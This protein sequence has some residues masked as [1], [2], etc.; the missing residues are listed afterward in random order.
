MND[1]RLALKAGISHQPMIEHHNVSREAV[2]NLVGLGFG[3]TFTSE[4]GA[5]RDYSNVSIKPIRGVVDKLVYQGVWSSQN[6]NP[7]FRCFL[8]LAQSRSKALA[9]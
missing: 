1:Y 6:D 4:A 8:S 9:G 3:V 5:S 2:M 7:A